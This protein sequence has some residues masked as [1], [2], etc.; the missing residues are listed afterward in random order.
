M[1]VLK[2]SGI[3][4]SYL[5]TFAN[6]GEIISDVGLEKEST[7]LPTTT[8]SQHYMLTETFAN[9]ANPPSSAADHGSQQLAE[10]IVYQPPHSGRRM[11]AAGRNECQP[12]NL[13]L[14]LAQWNHCQPN[15]ESPGRQIITLKGLIGLDNNF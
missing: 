1:F 2:L 4:I 3:K 14:K 10:N 5:G 9:P 12:A 8:V 6:F 13:D 7:T 11:A 15:P